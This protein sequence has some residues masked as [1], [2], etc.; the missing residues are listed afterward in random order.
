[1][2]LAAGLAAAGLL[3][4]AQ[5]A[6]GPNIPNIAGRVLTVLGPIDP[7]ALGPTLMHEH[8]FI[9]FKAPPPMVPAPTGITVVKPPAAAAGAGLRAGL[10][11]FDESL[12]EVMEF[13]KVGGGTI[14]DVT[15]FGLTRD[16][17]ALMRIAKASGLNVVMGAGWYQKAL[18][19][20]DM[21]DRT[22]QELT[23]I[24]VGDVTR[25]A[26][27]TSIRSGIIG[28]VGVQGHPLV[29]NELKSVRA[30]ARAARLTGA[31][32]TI[33]SFGTDEE[34]LSVLDIIAS[35]GVAMSR[36]VMG[37]MASR[38]M[39][40]LKQLYDRGVY[41]E[42]DYLGQAPL[43]PERTKQLAERIV[44]AVQSGFSDRLL[45]AHDICT[46]PQLKKNGGGGYTYIS[47]A[48]VPELKARGIGDDTIRRI[49]VDNPRR[50]L[51][52]AAPLPAV[53]AP[54][55]N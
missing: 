29:A 47:T 19:P 37:H 48:I 35:E 39:A 13:K 10:T 26:Q 40:Y 8:I 41:F 42:F 17:E 24:V 6:P 34:M 22:V 3:G 31:P 9:D 23:E 44:T 1:M 43:T 36:V 18:H 27:G 25:G 4:A 53:D 32:M 20:S 11:N 46:Q 15:N 55:S 52:F 51:T 38:D 45:V 21:T 33:H 30:S 14:V 16:P 12:T 50:V 7:A 28:E 5:T 49:L 54:R 2:T